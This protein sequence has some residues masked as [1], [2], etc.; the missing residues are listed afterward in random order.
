MEWV[1]LTIIIGTV[2]ILSFALGYNAG[3][4]RGRMSAHHN[5]M[6]YVERVMP[7]RWA[8]YKLGI[9]EG[10]EQGIADEAAGAYPTEEART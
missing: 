2:G 8:A 3:V 5:I 6:K 7:S 9:K 1:F 4:E 10:Y